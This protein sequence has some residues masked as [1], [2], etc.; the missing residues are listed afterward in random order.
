MIMK[1]YTRWMAVATVLA[2]SAP[3]VWALGFRNPDQGARATAQGEAFVA[4]ADD[5]SAIYY[6]PAGLTQVDGT[7][8]S[9]G[10]YV[11]FRDIEFDGAAGTSAKLNDPAYTAHLYACTDLKLNQWRL[12]FGVNMPFGTSVDWGEDS[13]FVNSVTESEMLVLN[14]Q[15]TLAYKINDHFAVGVGLN[16]YDGTATLENLPLAPLFS[17]AK[18]KFTGDGMAVGT[19]VGVLYKLNQQHSFGA[20][21][22]SPF[23]IEFDGSAEVENSPL[24]GY[25]KSHAQAIID[26]PQ[27]AVVG[28][29]FRPIEKL[30]LEV[31]VEWTD[32]DVLNDVRL[33]TGN[34]LDGTTLAYRYNSSFFYEVGAQ[35]EFTENWAVR[36]GYI[37]SENSVPEETFSATVPD[38][39][40]HIVSAGVGFTGQYGSLDLVYQY[41]ITEKRD[42]DDAD[43]AT[44]NGTW[45][46]QSHAVMLTATVKF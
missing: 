34:A 10:G 40:R 46:S 21:Y 27:S 15:P 17:A 9:A 42:V 13:P 38:G 29:A 39:N 44:V 20:T 2:A 36:A 32:W 25:G 41:S 1:S 22:R 3:A 26:F 4:Q 45:E 33:E 19:T 30:K 24:P 5:P 16:I 8:I 12:G 28:Y 37:F 6:N 43:N 11:T 31:D 7:Q 14:Y 23:R 18:L 35:Y